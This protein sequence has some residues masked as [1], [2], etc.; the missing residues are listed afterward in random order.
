[1]SEERILPLAQVL[2]RDSKSEIIRDTLVNFLKKNVRR[3][4]FE[5][6]NTTLYTVYQSFNKHN[7]LAEHKQV[8]FDI[9]SS[10]KDGLQ[11]NQARILAERVHILEHRF[12]GN[13]DAKE[14]A[15]EMFNKFKTIYEAAPN[16]LPRFEVIDLLMK[17][18]AST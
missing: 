1:M 3:L 18:Y 13:E 16:R 12:K 10:L 5:E 14:L 7:K 15:K 2:L 9:L 11:S 6:L 4:N 17:T 8:E